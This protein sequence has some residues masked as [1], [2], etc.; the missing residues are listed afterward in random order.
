MTSAASKDETLGDLNPIPLAI[1]AVS[2]MC[3]LVYGLSVR[4]PYV[5]LSNVPGSIASIWYITA[6]VSPK[7]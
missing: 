1:M 5:T 7:Q 3:W 2:S 4:D 6:V